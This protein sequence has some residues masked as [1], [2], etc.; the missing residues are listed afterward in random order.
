MRMTSPRF[1]SVAL[2]GSLLFAA[3]S[4]SDG[5]DDSAKDIGDTDTTAAAAE[6]T[7]TTTAAE[8]TTTVEETT[9]TVE[10]TTTTVAEPATLQGPADGVLFT[11]LDGQYS[12]LIGPGWIDGSDTFPNGIQGWFTGNQT[13]A[14]GE[15]VNIVTNGVPSSTPLDLAITASID[16]LEATF[17]GFTLIDSGVIPGLNHPELGYL[18]YTAIQAGTSIRFV[19]T[20][21]LWDDTLVVFT[22]S[23]DAEGGEAA[24]DVLLEYA[25]TIAPPLGS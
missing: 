21:G 20:F 16:Q 1:V 8:T 6:D 9:T 24:V 10:E 11:D 2:A 4:G 14:F 18:E 15:N 12:L 13:A 19:Q 17:E 7:T 5:D 3:C 25:V 23:T 22:G